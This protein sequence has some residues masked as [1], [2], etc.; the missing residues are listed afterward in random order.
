MNKQLGTI[1]YLEGQ[2]YITCGWSFVCKLG[3]VY[4]SQP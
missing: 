2:S 3:L 4:S 1:V